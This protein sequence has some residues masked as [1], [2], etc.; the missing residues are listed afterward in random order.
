MTD[1]Q[2][3][4]LRA[5]EMGHALEV[6]TG[7]FVENRTIYNV[8]GESNG[9]AVSFEWSDEKGYIW[10]VDFTEQSLNEAKIEGNQIR[11]VDLR[12]EEIVITVF[13]FEPAQV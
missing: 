3:R 11:M 12:G 10:E 4:I 9:I 1:T 13:Q 5:I 7:L 2:Q 6:G 8:H